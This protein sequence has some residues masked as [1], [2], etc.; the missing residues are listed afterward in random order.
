ML[1]I[2]KMTTISGTS[3]LYEGLN[4]VVRNFKLYWNNIIL[5]KS[6]VK[7]Y[8]YHAWKR[9]ISVIHIVSMCGSTL[10]FKTSLSRFVLSSYMN[11]GQV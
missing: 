11:I 8:H 4:V 1:L 6:T 3:N 9:V 10:A 2:T 7:K 5:V